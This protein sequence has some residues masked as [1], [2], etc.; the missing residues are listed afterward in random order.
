MKHLTYIEVDVP[1]FVEASP[2]SI[3][4][5]RFTKPCD[6]LPA[7]I[8]AIASLTNVTY[9]PSVISLGQTLGT[10]ASLDIGF[11]D[12]P[13]I[14]AG[15]PFRQ[16]SFWGKWRARYGL[17]L[18]GR[19][20]RW[21]QGIAGQTLAEM[22]VRHFVIDS[23][24]GPDLKG[25]YKI[26]AKDILKFADG[27]R[28]QAPR[29]SQGF[30]GGALSSSATNFSLSPAGIGNAEYPASGYVCIG[31]N[32]ICAFT[33]AGDA[34]TVTRGQFGTE[35]ASHDAG[36]R[37]QLCLHYDAVDPANIIR[38][39]LVTYAGVDPAY[40]PLSDW[41]AETGA[42]LQRLYTTLIPEPTDVRQLVS[43]VIEQS[44]LAVWWEPLEQLIKLQVLRGIATGAEA[45]TPDNV[46]EGSVG[47]AEQPNARVSEVWVYFGQRNPTRGLDDIDNFRST[48]IVADLEA[49]D[50][51]GGAA[52]K[53]IFSRWI[54]FGALSVA[55]RLGAIQLAR[56]KDPPRKFGFEVF[57]DYQAGTLPPRLGGGYRLAAWPLQ[58]VTGLS[59][60]A[61][62]Q[63]VKLDPR[64]ER[65]RVEAE[66]IL[67]KSFDPDDLVN[68]VITINS[69]IN[70][71]NLREMHDDIYPQITGAE[72]PPV[73]VTCIITSGAIVGSAS[74]SLPAFNVGDWP[75]GVPITVQLSG[76]IQGAGGN[77]GHPEGNGLPGGL[78]LYTRY[79]IDLVLNVGAGQIWGGG[80]GG[81]GH[82]DDDYGG[83]GGAGWIAGLGAFGSNGTGANGTTEFGGGG[84][85]SAGD[86]G[87]PAQAGQS[88]S[89]RSGGAAGNAID[90][91]SFI[92]KTGAGDI[93]GA[94]IN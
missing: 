48:A 82:N 33:R 56:F 88:S 55:Q 59:L 28:A 49:E 1:S 41:L 66:E 6:Y 18:R 69:D 17:K 73:T 58:D 3:V 65:Y 91:V 26:T 63:V 34:L 46:L 30:I 64:P 22:E 47:I 35:A 11:S 10:R 67:F 80:G 40:V 93:R 83:G 19:K 71:V 31:G 62:V 5:Y 23:T 7:D 86:G 54:P 21:Y 42:Y 16:G 45:Y 15:E 27:D 14:F 84:A 90:G 57:R 75:A 37:V 78:A 61:S 2:E 43:E 32:E 60:P 72:D 53:K 38:D 94:Q 13:H 70:T 89:Q 8:E 4:T 85:G 24:S 76:R 77:G 92:T 52:I 81:G 39:L 68:R 87:G 50:T 25:A 9:T 12:H 79:P 51:Y 29:L 20:L 44:A 36:S 74:T